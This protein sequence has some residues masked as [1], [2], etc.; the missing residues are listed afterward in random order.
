MSTIECAFT[1]MDLQNNRDYVA[2]SYTW[3]QTIPSIP[4]SVNG[5]VAMITDNLYMALLHLRKGGITKVWVDALCI[6]QNNLH[7]WSTQVSQ[8]AQVYQG[9]SM[10]YMWLGESNELTERAFDELHGLTQHVG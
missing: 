10:V 3:G 2:L 9:A 4:I 6:N 8:M 5:T 1:Y 7:E